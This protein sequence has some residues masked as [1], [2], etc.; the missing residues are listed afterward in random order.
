M[1]G[2]VPRGIAA[3]VFAAFV[4]AP[5]GAQDTGTQP[6]LGVRVVAVQADGS[7]GRDAGFD[8]AQKPGESFSAFV[9]AGVADT[10]GQL[11]SMRTGGMGGT[12]TD[13]DRPALQNA[14]FLWKFTHAFVAYE[15]G[16]QTFDFEWQRF[17]RGATSPAVSGKQRLVLADG[18]SRVL[19]LVHGDGAPPCRTASVVFEVTTKVKEDPAFADTVLRY[20]MWLV[21][22]DRNGRQER[23]HVILTGLHGTDA[24]FYFPVLT[25][26]VPKLQPDQYEFRVVTRVAGNARGRLTRDGRVVLN[27]ETSRSDSLE[28][29]GASAVRPGRGGSG[30]KVLTT[31]LGEAIEIELPPGNGY[32]SSPISDKAKAERQQKAAARAGTAQAPRTEPVVVTNGALQVNYGPFFQGERVSVIVQV[33]KADDEP[34]QVPAPISVV[35]R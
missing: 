29:P 3:C 14:L 33:R 25:S 7:R 1:R 28:R 20:D 2:Y 6:V 32:T 27:L 4:P 24:D 11:C 5:A 15:A 30:R 10:Q 8:V 21:R 16:R 34:A 22:T 19:D 17:D 35:A 26:E 23:R 12:M 9:Q 18:E 31:N 13:R